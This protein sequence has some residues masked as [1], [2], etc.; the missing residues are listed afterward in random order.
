MS[1]QTHELTKDDVLDLLSNS[2]R[3][4]VIYFLE[5]WNG[6]ATLNDLAY[7]IASQETGVPVD[8]LSEDDKRR[9]YISLYQTHLP[10][11]DLYG[12]V[13]YD[14]DDRTVSLTDDADDIGDYFFPDRGDS[15]SLTTYFIGLG[16]IGSLAALAGVLAPANATLLLAVCLLVSLLVTGLAA[17]MYT[18]NGT[19]DDDA[20]FEWLVDDTRP[21]DN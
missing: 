15:Q 10:K 19:S 12:L 21:G 16:A 14:K 18:T 6:S 13:D 20:V 7:N 1:Q 2:R 17:Y 9:V 3:R 8:D 5:Q 4:Y 11:L